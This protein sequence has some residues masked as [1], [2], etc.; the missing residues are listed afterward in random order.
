MLE[1]R[2]DVRW[3]RADFCQTALC[4]TVMKQTKH[5][6]LRN[7]LH[8]VHGSSHLLPPPPSP[9]HTHQERGHSHFRVF[10]GCYIYHTREKTTHHIRYSAFPLLTQPENILKYFPCSEVGVRDKIP[11]HTLGREGRGPARARYLH[12]DVSLKA[13]KRSRPTSST[14]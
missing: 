6:S 13:K 12:F 14:D 5:L 7:L 9:P 3:A 8:L 10:S 2:V 4:F 1:G 11:R